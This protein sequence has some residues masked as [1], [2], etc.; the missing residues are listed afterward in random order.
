MGRRPANGLYESRKAHPPASYRKRADTKAGGRP[1]E[2][3][4]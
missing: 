4:Q 2:Y 3:Q 1:V